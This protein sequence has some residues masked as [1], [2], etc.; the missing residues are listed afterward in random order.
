MRAL[1]KKRHGC[2]KRIAVNKSW[3]GYMPEKIKVIIGPTAV[4]KT[5]YSIEQAL[6]EGAEIISADSMQVYRQM[7]IGTAKPSSSEMHGVRHHLLDFI[8]PD[9]DWNLHLF[10]Q[11][12]RELLDKGKKYIVVGGTGLY[13]KALTHNYQTPLPTS[14]IA[15]NRLLEALNTEGL[16]SLYER[17]KVVDE[18]TAEKVSPNDKFRIIRALAAYESSGIP[19]SKQ[20]NMDKD[21]YERFEITCL[22]MPRA[23]LYQRI[24]DRVDNM[25]S[26]GL[27]EEVS[28]LLKRGYG[29]S[30]SSMQALGYKEMIICLKGLLPFEEA[31]ALIKKR[32][33]NFAKRQLTWFRS[34]P[35]VKWLDL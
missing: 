9:E 34:F 18:A 16:A 2:E 5:K 35:A 33:R 20:R 8:N 4:G 19:I 13:I 17:L 21:Y 10:L 14:I 26:N 3:E 28:E 30:L 25:V 7:D 29:E 23:V 15:E 12:A 1:D 32:T 22:N 31:V 27:L 24:E 11:K 6:K